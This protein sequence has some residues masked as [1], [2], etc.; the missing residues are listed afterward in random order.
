MVSFNSIAKVAKVSKKNPAS[1]VL[2][3][4]PSNILGA[5]AKSKG[6]TVR[7]QGIGKVWGKKNVASATMAYYRA[8]NGGIIYKRKGGKT[9]VKDPVLRKLNAYRRANPE[10]T[11]HIKY[12]YSMKSRVMRST[13]SVLAVKTSEG[14]KGWLTEGGKFISE[15]RFRELLHN[16]DQTS[17]AATSDVSLLDMWD[18]MSAQQKAELIDEMQ[19]FDWDTFWE[20]I[21][22]DDPEG[23]LRTA[24]NAYYELI[25]T[26]GDLMGW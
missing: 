8:K 15:D 14:Q 11:V 2:G 12:V 7:K 13:D 26:I 25:G 1:A 16:V 22:S 19:D 20:E 18:S 6:V 24:T 3:G 4:S 23:D 21:G 9:S 5:Y 17:P 10:Q